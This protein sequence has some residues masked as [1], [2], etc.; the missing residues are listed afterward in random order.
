MKGMAQQE[1]AYFNLV[2]QYLPAR[3]DQ[4]ALVLSSL[5]AITKRRRRR[6]GVLGGRPHTQG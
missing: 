3:P 6:R 1:A 5:N 2:E 4:P